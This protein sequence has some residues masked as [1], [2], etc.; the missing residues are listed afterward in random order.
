MYRNKLNV[1]DILANY[2]PHSAFHRKNCLQKRG[3]GS[4]AFF[5]SAFLGT[6]FCYSKKCFTKKNPNDVYIAFE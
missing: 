4:Q 6:F 5:S 1:Y 2:F 3:D